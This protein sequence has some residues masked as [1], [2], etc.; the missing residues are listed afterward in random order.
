MQWLLAYLT[1][2][3]YPLNN[4]SHYKNLYAGFKFNT[5]KETGREESNPQPRND[6]PYCGC[7]LAEPAAHLVVDCAHPTKLAISGRA[8]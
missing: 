8:K 1:H 4:D 7:W 5:A 6:K 2:L 3:S